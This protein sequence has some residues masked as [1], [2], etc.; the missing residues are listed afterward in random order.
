M[1]SPVLSRMRNR[2]PARVENA[3]RGKNIDGQEEGGGKRVRVRES[4][5]ED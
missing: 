2:R 5:T 4:E 1:T 3:G